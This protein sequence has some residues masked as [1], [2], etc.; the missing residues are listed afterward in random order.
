MRSVL[1]QSAQIS[2]I[3]FSYRWPLCFF[4]K[5]VVRDRWSLTC[6]KVCALSFTCQG[7]TS[8][9]RYTR[10]PQPVQHTTACVNTLLTACIVLF[11]SG[12]S[13][14]GDV[15]HKSR[16]GAGGRRARWKDGVR[17]SQSR[18]GLWGDQVKTFLKVEDGGDRKQNCMFSHWKHGGDSN[19]VLFTTQMSV[20]GSLLAVGGG[21]RRTANVIAH[22][23]ANLFILDKKD[24]NEI[25]VH[26]PDSKK[27]LRKKARLNAC[28][29]RVI[30]QITFHA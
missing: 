13:W 5:R 2:V 1:S 18:I 8:A 14:P 4:V 17:H 12:W 11:P 10:G 16:G 28:S 21:N 3:R 24:L 15:Y 6:W 23:F 26:Y 7:I 20:I 29:V 27:L 30:D 9:G 19:S 22:G 25:L